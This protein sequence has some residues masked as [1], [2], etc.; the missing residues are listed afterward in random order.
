MNTRILK[1]RMQKWVNHLDE[2]YQAPED[3]PFIKIAEVVVILP[4]LG[5]F[6][7][8]E[9]FNRCNMPYYL[10]FEIKDSLAVLYEN[11]MPIIYISTVLSLMLTIMVPIILKTRSKQSESGEGA[12]GG[13]EN[14]AQKTRRISKFTVYVTAITVLLGLLVLLKAYN[15]DFRII[16]IFLVLGGVAS[17]IYLFESR[18]LGFGLA[19]LFAFLYAEVRANIDA[20]HA[21]TVK[22][23]MDIML[24]SF[25]DNPILTEGEKC[26]YL[27][28]KSSNYYFIKDTCT[29]RIEVYSS[30]TGEMNSFKSE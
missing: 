3:K 10:Y 6:Y 18:N 17:Y 15:F 27:L 13:Q 21:M 11:L 29:K 5:F 1:D 22:P 12:N 30:S 19:V 20:K 16:A 9:Y 2:T 25:S 7:I 14:T 26:R 28:Y 8:W 23:R 4:A 24:K